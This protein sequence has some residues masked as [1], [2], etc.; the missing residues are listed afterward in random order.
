MSSKNLNK[1]LIFCWVINSVLFFNI[2]V[3]FLSSMVYDFLK[4]WSVVILTT[5]KTLLM[6]IYCWL[7][8]TRNYVVKIMPKVWFFWLKLRIL[9][10]FLLILLLFFFRERCVCKF[11]LILRDTSLSWF[12]FWHEKFRKLR[13]VLK[14]IIINFW[15]C[16]NV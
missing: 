14:C 8:F 16:R 15:V 9:R 1:L 4:W 10:D 6:L 11:L 12:M 3:F 7:T 13:K 5:L 2:V